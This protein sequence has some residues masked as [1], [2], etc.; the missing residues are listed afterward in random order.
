MKKMTRKQRD[1]NI[2]KLFPP[3]ADSKPMMLPDTSIIV[4]RL[5]PVVAPPTT[6]KVMAKSGPNNAPAKKRAKNMTHGAVGF[7]SGGGAATL[8]EARTVLGSDR[9]GD[10][11]LGVVRA[12]MLS[13]RDGNSR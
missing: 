4:S 10:R 5:L 2:Q 8:G 1:R 11:C 12:A 13:A 3:I 7:C 9:V 6:P